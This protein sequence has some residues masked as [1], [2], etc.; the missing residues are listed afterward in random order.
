MRLGP[1]RPLVQRLYQR[2]V[3]LPVGGRVPMLRGCSLSPRRSRRDPHRLRAGRRALGRGRVAPAVPVDHRHR[4][5]PGMRPDHRR[6]GAAVYDAA[7]GQAGA[8]S[9]G[10]GALNNPAPPSV[11]TLGGEPTLKRCARRP[12]GGNDNERSEEWRTSGHRTTSARFTSSICR[13]RLSATRGSRVRRPDRLIG[14]KRIPWKL[15]LGQ[16]TVVRA[17]SARYRG[18][19]SGHAHAHTP[20]PGRASQSGP[21]RSAASRRMRNHPWRATTCPVECRTPPGQ[22]RHA[23]APTRR[24]RATLLAT[25]THGTSQA[26]MR[27]CVDTSLALNRPCPAQ[28]GLGRCWL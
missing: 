8:P 15:R 4:G 26:R 28:D 14:V 9:Q 20:N 1:G 17:I 18:C 22:A 12:C 24:F 5:G 27:R 25:P 6:L 23:E 7:P 19:R 3:G 13:L 21:R 10:P 2:D 16:T 11:S